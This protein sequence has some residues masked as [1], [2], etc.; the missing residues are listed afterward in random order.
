MPPAVSIFGLDEH[1][2]C[3]FDFYS[4]QA[5]IKGIGRVNVLGASDYS[6]R[7]WMDA[8]AM[9]SVADEVLHR[10]WFRLLE[11][12]TLVLPDR[13]PV[14]VPGARSAFSVLGATYRHAIAVRGD[15]FVL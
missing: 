4:N 9:A 1:T 15:A 8:E 2:A 14:P 3:I 11:T 12:E 7:I 10:S 6:M 5:I 13:P